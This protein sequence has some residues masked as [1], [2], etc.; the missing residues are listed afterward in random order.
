MSKESISLVGILSRLYIVEVF[1]PIRQQEEDEKKGSCDHTSTWIGQLRQDSPSGLGQV[2]GK[3]TRDHQE[4][5][6]GCAGQ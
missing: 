4:L 5:S 3:A 2:H 6:D 1:F